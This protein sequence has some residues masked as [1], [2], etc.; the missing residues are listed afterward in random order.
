MPK[1]VQR[2]CLIATLYDFPE[3]NDIFHNRVVRFFSVAA[4]FSGVLR[5]EP[6]IANRVPTMFAHPRRQAPF[7]SKLS[8]S[9]RLIVGSAPAGGARPR[10]CERTHIVADR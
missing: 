6:K 1:T 3:I 7:N 2:R 4:T 8:T 5:A 10:G 9:F